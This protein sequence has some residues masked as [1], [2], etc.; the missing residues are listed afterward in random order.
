VPTPVVLTSEDLEPDAPTAEAYES[1]LVRFV[2]PKVEVPDSCIGEFTLDTGVGVDDLF[3]GADAPSPV[4]GDQF[5]AVSGPLR[6]TFNGFEI[7]PRTAA[8]VEP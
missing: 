4:A 5:S 8:D 1:A 3:L 6:Y 7:A 2:N